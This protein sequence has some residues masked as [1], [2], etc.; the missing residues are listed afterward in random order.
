MTFI[1]PAMRVSAKTIPMKNA[2]T[3][4][5]I[6]NASARD[7]ARKTVPSAKRTNSSSLLMRSK[8]AAVRGTT[9]AA[10]RAKKP[11][12]NPTPPN[13]TPTFTGAS[14]GTIIPLTSV[15]RNMARNDS[16]ITMPSRNSV[17]AFPSRFRSISDFA[18]IAEL[19]MLMT[20]AM[21]IVS[22]RGHPSH[23]PMTNPANMFTARF[24]T[25]RTAAASFV[26]MSFVMLN[27]R[28]T[29]KRS[30]TRPSCEMLCRNT[31]SA[32]I[33]SYDQPN[34]RRWMLGPISIPA[35]M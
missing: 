34:S 16:R 5:G 32:R 27:S 26:R 35:M 15:R 24:V 4:A 31:L 25:A 23:A 19:D 28:P 10:K 14:D 12:N 9:T 29:K 2:P 6:R 1:R 17:S 3:M 21:K 18:V 13:R 33:P 22:I 30:R 7:A 20:P 11:M 8:I